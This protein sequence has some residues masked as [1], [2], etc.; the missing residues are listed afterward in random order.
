MIV[1]WM[2]LGFFYVFVL[3][4]VVIFFIDLMKVIEVEL[5]D[6]YFNLNVIMI[7]FVG[8]IILLL[9]N[10]GKNEYIFIVKK[11]GIDVVIELGKEKN[12]IVKFKNIGIYELIC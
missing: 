12:I 9:K 11:F 5:N 4:I 1:W 8:L 10:K 7:L 3:V 6:D 2:F